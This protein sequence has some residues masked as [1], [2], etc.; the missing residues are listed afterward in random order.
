MQLHAV[1][2]RRDWSVVVEFIDHG[3]S[4]AKSREQRPEFDTLMHGIRSPCSK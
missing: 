4:G 2:E 1:A 3:I